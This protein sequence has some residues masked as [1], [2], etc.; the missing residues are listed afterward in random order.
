MNR[1]GRCAGDGNPVQ[2]ERRRDVRETLFEPLDGLD[3][4]ELLPGAG[5]ARDHWD[6]FA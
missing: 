3:D 1:P 5:R 6:D 4:L 2:G